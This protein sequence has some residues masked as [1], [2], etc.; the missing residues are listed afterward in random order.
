MELERLYQ[1]LELPSEVKEALKMYANNRKCKVSSDIK[2]MLLCRKTWDAGI[3]RLQEIVGEDADGIK[4]LWELLNIACESYEEYEKR[5]IPLEIYVATMK[6]CTRFIV[7]HYRVHG[8]Y[9]FVWA[10]WFP[11]QLSLQEF[12]IGCLEYEFVEDDGK[13][14]FVHI[15]SDA[16]LHKNVVEESFRGFNVFRETFFPEWVDTQIFCESWLL[17]PALLEL[18]ND[19]SNIINFQRYFQVE[20]VD[21]DSMAVMDWVFPGFKQVTEQLPENTSLQRGM[22]RHLLEGKKIGWAIGYMNGGLD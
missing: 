2:E 13:R 17:S 16:D 22:K 3:E 15:P 21:Y 20:K 6:F 14:I 11:R 7:E 12:R 5:K 9:K 18:L 19:N 4:I 8:K 1:L 10:W